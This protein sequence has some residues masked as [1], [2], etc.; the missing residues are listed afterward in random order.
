MFLFQDLQDI[1][2]TLPLRLATPSHQLATQPPRLA[3]QV[4]VQ[5]AFLANTSQCLISQVPLQEYHGC[6]HHH[7]QQTVHL[8]W[9]I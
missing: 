6:R 5:W 3:I 4:L 8:D 7:L 9:S 1:L 2:A